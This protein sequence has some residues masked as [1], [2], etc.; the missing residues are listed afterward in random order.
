MK[1]LIKTVGISTAAATLLA[2]GS[3]MAG[4]TP[5]FAFVGEDTDPGND[6]YVS[7]KHRQFQY[8]GDHGA[9][10]DEEG[11]NPELFDYYDAS[12][13]TGRGFTPR[14][15]QCDIDFGDAGNQNQML[16]AGRAGTYEWRITMPMSM[17]GNMNLNIQCGLLKPNTERPRSSPAGMAMLDCAGE[18]GER[19]GASG[20]CIRLLDQP[21]RNPVQVAALP[22]LTAYA[23]NDAARI[24]FNLTAYR[25]PGRYGL[26]SNDRRLTNSASLQ[27]L[28]GSASSR[29]ALKSCFT[30]SIF[31]KIP[32]SGQVNAE[33]QE[34]LDLERGDTIAIQLAFPRDHRMDVYCHAQSASVTGIG[35][36]LSAIGV[37]RDASDAGI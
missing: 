26:T 37:R 33:G 6:F 18:T 29:I 30:K 7:P 19:I 12:G 32:V 25:N 10:L 31:V 36:P 8:S 16:G 34:E 15:E 21:G 17:R 23:R 4:Q 20:G 1:N 3:A 24:F 27:A 22:K 2:A 14:D 11:K 28:N 9:P 13:L 5:Y 35:E